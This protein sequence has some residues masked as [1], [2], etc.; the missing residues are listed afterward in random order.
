MSHPSALRRVFAPLRRSLTATFSMAAVA[1]LLTAVPVQAAPPSP[2]LYVHVS[3]SGRDV[4]SGTAAHPFRTLD[5][6][7]DYGPRHDS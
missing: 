2:D 5:H 3:P 7:R 6:A 4:G 1:A